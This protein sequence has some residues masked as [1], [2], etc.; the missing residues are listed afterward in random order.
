ME[1]ILVPRLLLAVRVALA[2]QVLHAVL[3]LFDDFA[4]GENVHLRE[5]ALGVH[6]VSN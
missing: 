4:A 3:G 6:V 2:E 1:A 5:E